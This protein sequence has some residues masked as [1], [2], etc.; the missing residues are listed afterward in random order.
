M[1]RQGQDQEEDKTLHKKQ[2]GERYSHALMAPQHQS[3]V[4]ADVSE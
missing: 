4:F 1:K 2:Q 3:E